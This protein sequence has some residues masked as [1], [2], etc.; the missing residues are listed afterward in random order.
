MNKQE[1]DNLT[2]H[3]STPEEFAAIERLYM[4]A[5][6]MTKTEAAKVWRRCF[7]GAA[8]AREAAHREPANRREL[9]DALREDCQKHPCAGRVRYIQ[10]RGTHYRFTDSSHNG[11]TVYHCVAVLAVDVER[12]E[13]RERDVGNFWPK[14]NDCAVYDDI[15]EAAA[16]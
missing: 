13:V 3:E 9:L 16:V 6:V 10:I 11:E 8:L 14:L 7:L 1:L 15:P 12:G 4:A 5:Q 2:K